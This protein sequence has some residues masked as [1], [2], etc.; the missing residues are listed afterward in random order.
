[1][2]NEF[3]KLVEIGL[4][5]GE[6]S[7]NTDVKELC[8]E[9]ESRAKGYDDENGNHYTIKLSLQPTNKPQK[10]EQK[11]VYLCVQLIN[12]DVQYVDIPKT[13]GRD[14]SFRSNLFMLIDAYSRYAEESA[15]VELIIDSNE[16]IYDA[17][18]QDY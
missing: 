14:K 11:Q 18:I 7:I 17:V 3:D 16:D 8:Q 13:V 12:D 1:M 15:D 2:K 9:I 4:A 10:A 6:N 5:C